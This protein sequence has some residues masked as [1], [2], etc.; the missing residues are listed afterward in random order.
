MLGCGMAYAPRRQSWRP[1]SRRRLPRRRLGGVGR[2]FF[3]QE[4]G[5]IVASVQTL[6]RRLDQFGDFLFLF[7]DEAHHAVA[8]QWAQ[9]IG[10]Y[11][12]AY[13]CGF[14]ATR[15]GHPA[16]TIF[17]ACPP[18]LAW[19]AICPRPRVFTPPGAISFRRAHGGRRLQQGNCPND[20]AL[21]P[22]V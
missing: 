18:G 13:I 15:N 12:S 17:V 6:A 9:V 21:P 1:V 14:T 8:G 16:E 7:L 11:P 5:V 20:E 4:A 3:N 22:P 19:R 10:R 2:S